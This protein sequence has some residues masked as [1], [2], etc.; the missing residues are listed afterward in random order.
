MTDGTPGC[1]P[2]LPRCRCRG[3]GH[4]TACKG[5]AFLMATRQLGVWLNCS[6]VAKEPRRS[7]ETDGCAQ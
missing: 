4:G 1:A 6:A 7:Q 5:L 2:A 3:N